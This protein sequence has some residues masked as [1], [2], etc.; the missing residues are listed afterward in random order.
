MLTNGGQVPWDDGT[1][2]EDVALAPA[3]AATAPMP[4]TVV[5]VAVGT[6]DEGADGQGVAVIES[7]K[8]QTEIKA[9]RAGVVDRLPVAVGDSFDQGAAVVVLQPEQEDER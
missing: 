5:S 1:I 2:P 6:G 3:V 8:M 4:G 9:P 7:M